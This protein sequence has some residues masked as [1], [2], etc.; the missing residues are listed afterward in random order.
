[1]STHIHS[2]VSV[3]PTLQHPCQHPY[4]ILCLSHP[5]YNTHV[6]TH[7]VLYPSHPPVN[8]HTVLCLSHPPYNTHQFSFQ[9]KVSPSLLPTAV[10]ANFEQ[11]AVLLEHKRLAP[12]FQPWFP[13]TIGLQNVYK[14][15]NGL[16]VYWTEALYI[17]IIYI[18]IYSP[19]NRTVSPQDFYKTCTLHKHKT[20]K[21]NPKLSP[22]G[23]ALI[24]SGNKV[25]RCWY[26]W[27]FRSGVS[28]PD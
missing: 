24:K 13:Q 26:H 4:T 16:F 18:I 20:Y 23:I 10:I 9:S 22:F 5:P 27:P 19:A 1:M 12:F 3:T 8:T 21:H 14:S 17:Y 11:F 2:P 6:N 25:R 7:T 28:I 15:Q